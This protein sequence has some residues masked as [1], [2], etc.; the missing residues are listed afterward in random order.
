MTLYFHKK[1]VSQRSTSECKKT[2]VTVRAT[3]FTKCKDNLE[4]GRRLEN[5]SWRLWYRSCHPPSSLLDDDDDNYD[6]EGLD[7]E[8]D[9]TLPELIAPSKASKRNT[10]VSEAVSVEREESPK[11]LP[12]NYEP[13]ASLS[14]R[15]QP[16]A[17]DQASPPSLTLS[18]LQQNPLENDTS[19]NALPNKKRSPR[20]QALRKLHKKHSTVTPASFTR[21][22]DMDYRKPIWTSKKESPSPSPSNDK[23]QENPS[24]TSPVYPTP[25]EEQKD[26]ADC[27]EHT[28]PHQRQRTTSSSA[29]GPYR[30]PVHLDDEEQQLF[31]P[32]SSTHGVSELLM[33]DDIIPW[34]IAPQTSCT[35]VSHA[36]S[37]ESAQ[38]EKEEKSQTQV[39]RPRF[40]ISSSQVSENSL[41]ATPSSCSAVSMTRDRV[42]HTQP[43]SAQELSASV[44]LNQ[45]LEQMS[46]IQ[47]ENRLARLADSLDMQRCPARAPLRRPSEPEAIARALS[48]DS[49]AT[50]DDEDEYISSGY[51]S[52]SYSDEEFDSDEETELSC[53]G[54]S[55]SYSPSPLFRKV[56]LRN[57]TE[58][59]LMRQEEPS[60][61]APPSFWP[62][63]Y[64]PMMTMNNRQSLLSAALDN[65]K[66]S[67]R[68]PQSLSGIS[69]SGSSHGQVVPEECN[70]LSHSVKQTLLWDQCMP[71]NTRMDPSNQGASGVVLLKRPAGRVN[72]SP[73]Q[74]GQEQQHQVAMMAVSQS[75]PSQE[76]STG[77]SSLLSW[78]QELG[79]Y[80]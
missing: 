27:I 78:N 40:F 5:I 43:P 9:D 8:E 69:R 19:I 59:P 60:S 61:R 10:L 13:S 20:T 42:P 48:D 46:P 79:A 34:P 41:V 76:P 6:E 14:S 22:L 73:T 50:F 70:G 54:E 18:N 3:V 16:A 56:T 51:S 2:H 12:L 17:V 37:S 29:P 45:S 44:S 58:N 65:R 30:A 11:L 32:S 26:S 52:A 66:R 39:E 1:K 68:M 49:D 74:Q 28:S 47:S 63:R 7:D 62:P 67:C 53:Y 36:Q 72:T 31:I 64:H 75:A 57:Q 38:K 55:W 33:P 4:N 23:P 77:E 24:T 35:L 71:F 80:W 15:S 21:V 25:T